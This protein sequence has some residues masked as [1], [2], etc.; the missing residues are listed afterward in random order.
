MQRLGRAEQKHPLTR[1]T[2]RSVQSCI[3]TCFSRRLLM[4]FPWVCPRWSNTIGFWIQYSPPQIQQK[5]ADSASSVVFS[6]GGPACYA[7]RRFAFSSAFFRVFLNVGVID[8]PERDELTASV[9]SCPVVSMNKRPSLPASRAAS[10]PLPVL[11]RLLFK[12]PLYGA[13]WDTMG[14]L[15]SERTVSCRMLLWWVP[16]WTRVISFSGCL[17]CRTFYFELSILG[18]G[19]E[20]YFFQ[21]CAFSVL[22]VVDS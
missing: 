15:G 17:G 10:R 1:M 22:L 21:W 8:G 18:F 14:W 12:V 11:A 2:V 7:K 4:P 5:I 6:I 3:W 19:F 9:R 13:S 20:T 16:D